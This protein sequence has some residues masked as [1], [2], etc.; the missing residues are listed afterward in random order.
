MAKP[1][2]EDC[3]D[4]GGDMEVCMNCAESSSNCGCDEESQDLQD[5]EGCKG[6]GKVCVECQEAS[7]NC[8]CEAA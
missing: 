1:D 2:L 5:C 4:C 7:V 8:E 3:S 6:T